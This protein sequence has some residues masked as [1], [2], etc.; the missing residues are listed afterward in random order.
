MKR[1]REFETSANPASKRLSRMLFMRSFGVVASYYLFLIWF[2]EGWFIKAGVMAG[3]GSTDGQTKEL[4][5]QVADHYSARTNQTREQREASP[6]IHLKK[7]NNWVRPSSYLRSMQRF[8]QW[9]DHVWIVMVVLHGY[10]TRVVDSVFI[11][12]TGQ[13]KSV[14]IQI[15]TARGDAVIDVAC[16]KVHSFWRRLANL[17]QSYYNLLEVCFSVG[18]VMDIHGF[19]F[20]YASLWLGWCVVMMQGGD[21]IKWDKASIGYYV[22]IDI[23]E[24]SVLSSFHAHDTVMLE[25]VEST[26]SA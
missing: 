16:G 4:V 3:D 19:T 24:G 15:Y 22:G 2:I 25:M 18:I 1:G 20:W 8:H 10:F 11:C 6:I 12:V 26:I 9:R 7:L 5:R 17:C 21:L 23:A 13:I 14:L